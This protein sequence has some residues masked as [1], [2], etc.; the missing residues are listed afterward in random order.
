MSST[1]YSTDLRYLV[2]CVADMADIRFATAIF[3]T[4]A[5]YT[6]FQAKILK[7]S[8]KEEDL[9]SNEYKIIGGFVDSKNNKNTVKIYR[10]KVNKLIMQD[11]TLDNCDIW[12]TFDS[13]VTDNV[14][15]MDIIQHISFMQYSDSNELKLF[16][17]KE[18]LIDEVNNNSANN[19]IQRKLYKDS[20]GNYIELYNMK[21]YI[22][23][24]YIKQDR[25][26][27]YIELDNNRKCYLTK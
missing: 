19:N 16:K 10:Y 21:C 17:T 23:A 2:T 25:K 6:C 7:P 22:R 1:K 13:R 8:L 26:G 9:S 11:I 15:G 14:I 12:I 27:Y 24:S 18:E 20:R 3:D 5:M 4:G